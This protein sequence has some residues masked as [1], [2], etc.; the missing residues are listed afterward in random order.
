MVGFDR[1]KVL[2]WYCCLHPIE[3]EMLDAVSNAQGAISPFL[4]EDFYNALWLLYG[5]GAGDARR[6]AFESIFGVT[7][8]SEV[9]EGVDVPVVLLDLTFWTPFWVWKFETPDPCPDGCDILNFQA[10]H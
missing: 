3:G 8:G 2:L 4:L 9:I 10:M 6:V 1:D 5:G 7:H